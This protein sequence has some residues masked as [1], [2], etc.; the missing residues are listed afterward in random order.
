MIHRLSEC[1]NFDHP[2]NGEMLALPHQL[3]AL[4]KP[5]EIK[6]LR[7]FQSVLAKERN[8]RLNQ[9]ISFRDAVSIQVLFVVVVS[10]VEINLAH[11]EM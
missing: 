5:F 6:L 2:T 9:I 8:D 7:G 11:T 4:S 1:S 3:D 10:P